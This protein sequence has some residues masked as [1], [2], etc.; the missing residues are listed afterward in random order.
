MKFVSLSYCK[1][2]N[3]H[4]SHGITMA[5]TTAQGELSVEEVRRRALCLKLDNVFENFFRTFEGASNLAEEK[6]KFSVITNS[7][8]RCP[9]CP[10]KEMKFSSWLKHIR[11]R[12]C[13]WFNY[14]PSSSPLSSSAPRPTTTTLDVGDDEDSWKDTL[15]ECIVDGVQQ[16][17]EYLVKNR[18]TQFYGALD[19]ELDAYLP[20]AEAV[21]LLVP[22]AGHP[23]SSSP[24]RYPPESEGWLLNVTELL[25][26]AEEASSSEKAELGVDTARK[27]YVYVDKN[28]QA[29][30]PAC[31]LRKTKKGRAMLK[32]AQ[33]ARRNLSKDTTPQQHSSSAVLSSDPLPPMPLPHTAPH[34]VKV[35]LVVICSSIR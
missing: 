27:V 19:E 29:R 2:S 11:T 35:I 23:L 26:F 31:V 10:A 24:D 1:R 12:T 33:R 7:Y 15:I 34:A 25:P 18:N 6:V 14:S 17:K 13:A 9:L 30:V 32:R 16:W 5:N 22:A 3:R 8:F 20:E 4:E 28:T 21:H